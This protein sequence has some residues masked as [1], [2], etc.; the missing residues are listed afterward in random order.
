MLNYLLSR[1]VSAYVFYVVTDRFSGNRIVAGLTI[2]FL[3]AT[4]PLLWIWLDLAF[5]I[6]DDGNGAVNR[7]SGSISAEYDGPKAVAANIADLI[8]G[9]VLV[10]LYGMICWHATAYSF[11][12]LG[13]NAPTLDDLFKEEPPISIIVQPAPALSRL[14]GT[15]GANNIVARVVVQ[16][17]AR[18]LELEASAKADITQVIQ[19][20]CG[21]NNTVLH[22][23][24][25]T[26]AD[27][28]CGA[29]AT[30]TYEV[31]GDGNSIYR[32][33]FR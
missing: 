33:T 12:A 5:I 17:E 26:H 21:A 3:L 6:L 13:G 25:G 31:Y 27:I 24:S 8:A 30:T 10:V 14:D 15:V 7:W 18:G 16:L 32:L 1:A 11:E 19:R 4:Y 29:R 9:F 2:A 28:L 22:S 23:I 20:M